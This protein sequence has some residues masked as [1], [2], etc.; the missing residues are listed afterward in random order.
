LTPRT[1]FPPESGWITSLS[2]SKISYGREIL[3][4]HSDLISESLVDGDATDIIY[5]FSTSTL[6]PSYRALS[7]QPKIPGI[8]GWEANGTEFSRNKIPEF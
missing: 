2:G 5:S 3:N 4:I 6:T 8:P 7:I 1:V